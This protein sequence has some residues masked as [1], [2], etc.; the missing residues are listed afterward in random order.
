MWISAG[1][2]LAAGAF[3]FAWSPRRE[4][5]SDDASELFAAEPVLEVV[6][7]W[8]RGAADDIDAAI[9]VV[10]ELGQ[11]IRAPVASIPDLLRCLSPADSHTER[12]RRLRRL[13]DMERG[14]SPE[15]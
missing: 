1:L 6:G 15:P 13:V 11:G 2:A 12:E 4:T 10:G 5:A 7:A 9:W 14:L 3:V 8:I